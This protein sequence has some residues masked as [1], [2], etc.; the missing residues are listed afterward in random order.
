MRRYRVSNEKDP[1][2]D[3]HCWKC[4]WCI[5]QDGSHLIFIITSRT[6]SCCCRLWRYF[7]LFILITLHISDLL[8]SVLERSQRPGSY[9]TPDSLDFVSE[10]ALPYPCPLTKRNVITPITT[11]VHEI[12]SSRS[13]PPCLPLAAR[14][15]PPSNPPCR[16]FHHCHGLMAKNTLTNP[17]K[18]KEAK[19]FVKWKNH[20]SFSASNV[21]A[22]IFCPVTVVVTVSKGSRYKLMMGSAMKPKTNIVRN[23]MPAVIAICRVV[24]VNHW[25]HLILSKRYWNLQVGHSKYVRLP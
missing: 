9:P 15:V 4:K 5:D 12:F 24:L 23:M 8:T 20:D 10:I 6:T 25:L 17:S 13:R 14:L 2:C 16:M 3:N 18:P 11:T 1:Y 21:I 7:F 22:G 19:P